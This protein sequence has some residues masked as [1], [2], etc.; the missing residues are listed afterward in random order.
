MEE[1]SVLRT[2]AYAKYHGSMSQPTYSDRYGYKLTY[3]EPLFD[4]SLKIPGLGIAEVPFIP[5]QHVR[6]SR[7]QRPFVPRHLTQEDMIQIN[8]RAQR[9]AKDILKDFHPSQRASYE[10]SSNFLMRKDIE[11]KLEDIRETCASTNNYFRKA[12]KYDYT[13]KNLYN[14]RTKPRFEDKDKIKDIVLDSHVEHIK[15]LTKSVGED[16]NN[17]RAKFQML[18]A[19]CRPSRRE[20][21]EE[22]MRAS[23]EMQKEESVVPELPHIEAVTSAVPHRKTSREH[24]ADQLKVLQDRIEKQETESD[25]FERTFGRHLSKLRGEVNTLSNH[26]DEYLTDTRYKT[27]KTDQVLKRY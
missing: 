7:S 2:P 19:G 25:C 6:S 22:A 27:F 10:S 15:E 21:I 17:H 16:T 20:M 4:V 26:T 18:S 1:F 23:D 24:R 12:E 14:P 5:I 3:Y 13:R 8:L 11:Q 9:K